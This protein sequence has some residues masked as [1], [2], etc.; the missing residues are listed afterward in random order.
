M[1]QNRVLVH[2]GEFILVILL[3]I[4]FSL[5]V[6]V[7]L[8]FGVLRLSL[9]LVAKF[10]RPD[11]IPI[12]NA[13]DHILSVAPSTSKQNMNISV[14][15]ILEG[16]IDIV[17]FRSHFHEL[18]FSTRELKE[19]YLNLLCNFVQWGQ[20]I[21]K[22]QVKTINLAEQ[23]KQTKIKIA[24][25]HDLELFVEEYTNMHDYEDKLNWEIVLI[26]ANIKIYERD[27][28]SEK[29]I[30]VMKF[31]HGLLDGYSF[32]HLVGKLCGSKPPYL[33]KDYHLSFSDKVQEF[34]FSHS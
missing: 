27:T 3:W 25:L 4:P 7:C 2:I 21:W 1:I 6:T 20:Y 28:S 10:C 12:L 33:V 5:V 30:L 13:A 18:F 26:T 11:L 22:K 19:R 34:K 14:T 16:K 15:W 8:L 23:I 17:D 31:H 29:T 24:K 9:I 32:I